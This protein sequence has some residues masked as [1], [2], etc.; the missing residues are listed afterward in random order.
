M[1]RQRRSFGKIRT[2]HKSGKTYLEASYPTPLDALADNPTLPK[3]YYKTLAQQYKPELEAWLADAEKQIKLGSWQPPKRILHK[4]VSHGMTIGRLCEIYLKEVR[5]SDGS[6]LQVTTLAKKEERIRLYILPAFGTT[7]VDKL[8][9]SDVQKWYESFHVTPDGRGAGAQRNALT[10]LKAILNFAKKYEIDD[11]GNTIITTNPC[12]T[13]TA[14]PKK[15][16]DNRIVAEY[17]ELDTIAKHMPNELALAIY[18]GGVCGLREGEICALT[19]GDIDTQEH[20]INISKA[21]K[22]YNR[23]GEHRHLIVG[24][25]KTE[26]SIRKILYPD[27]MTEHVEAHLNAYTGREQDSLLFE[28]KK[29]A[30]LAPTSL[31]NAWYRAR[32]Y[33]PR[34]KDMRFHDLRHTALTHYGESGARIAQL[35][36]VAGHSDIKT[37]QVYQHVSKTHKEE[38][39]RR[40]EE[41]YNQQTAKEDATRREPASSDPLVNVIANLDIQNMVQVLRSL[42]KQ[43]QASIIAQL[44][45]DVQVQVLPL[46]L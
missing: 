44:P 37:V 17:D 28:G 23:I 12:D 39:V 22:Q 30:L 9:A 42:D 2:I 46:L 18:L 38:A 29:G 31:R 4:D 11:Q 15:R 20:T 25:P 7:P 6:K 27:W 13:I 33:V 24:S 19:R 41:Q 45:T 35:M 34:L 40:L 16:A 21:V 3:R 5:K 32:A 1:P 14:R 8:R 10:V 26:A 36:Q 43:R